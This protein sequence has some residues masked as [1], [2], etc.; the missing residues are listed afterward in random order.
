MEKSIFAQ[1]N[2]KKLAALSVKSILQ[3]WVKLTEKNVNTKYI[4]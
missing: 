4:N 1:T 2:F 3:E